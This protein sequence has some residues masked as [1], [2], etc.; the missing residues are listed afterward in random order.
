MNVWVSRHAADRFVERVRPGMTSRDGSIEL[1]RLCREFGRLVPRPA[2]APDS[3]ALH[4]PDYF[5]V[6]VADGIVVVV[7][8]T[9]SRRRWPQ[10][11][12]VLTRAGRP[13]SRRKRPPPRIRKLAERSRDR[14]RVRRDRD[15]D[16]VE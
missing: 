8:P 10:A 15:V 3:E 11:V 2:W 13:K 7:A 1:A 14:R 4:G 9:E 6:E 5:Y 16:L 12:T